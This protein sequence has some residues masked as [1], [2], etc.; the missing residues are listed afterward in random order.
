MSGSK[1][2]ANLEPASQSGHRW[3]TIVVWDAEY[4]IQCECCH[5]RMVYSACPRTHPGYGQLR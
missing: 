2:A 4:T 1:S 3:T 5:Q